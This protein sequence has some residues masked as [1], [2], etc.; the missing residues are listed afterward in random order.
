MILNNK[1]PLQKAKIHII[2]PIY[3]LNYLK[4]IS[5]N[6]IFLAFLALFAFTLLIFNTFTSK[7]QNTFESVFYK[8]NEKWV[9]WLEIK[10]DEIIFNTW[11]IDSW[12]KINYLNP[13]DK[14]LSYSWEVNVSENNITLNNWIF[15]INISEIN[16][17]YKINWKW[18]EIKNNWPLTLYIDNWSINQHYHCPTIKW[19]SLAY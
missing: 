1:K 16:G 14:I 18:F 8:N 4:V 6:K 5:L 11:S 17:K 3:L 9:F 10:N 15:L 7:N 2:K 19:I 12:L 13:F